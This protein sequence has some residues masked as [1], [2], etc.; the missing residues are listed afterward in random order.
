MRRSGWYKLPLGNRCEKALLDQ[1]NS[2]E[3][4][5]YWEPGESL[6]PQ[7]DQEAPCLSPLLLHFTQEPPEE[8]AA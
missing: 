4:R 7:T 1:G 2:P 5:S 3:A 6:G 8:R